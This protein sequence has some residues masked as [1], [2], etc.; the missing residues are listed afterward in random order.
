MSHRRRGWRFRDFRV[1]TGSHSQG[2]GRRSNPQIP[3]HVQGHKLWTAELPTNDGTDCYVEIASWCP[4]VAYA[5]K[6][7]ECTI[8]AETG[9][10][11]SQV[12]T[13]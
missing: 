1:G 5:W 8:D 2:I 13:K 7:F 3:K 9:K 6:S 11:T 10:I 12:F 4:L